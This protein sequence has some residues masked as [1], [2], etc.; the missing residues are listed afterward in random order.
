MKKCCFIIPY[1]GKL[2]V[3]FQL[4]LYSCGRNKDF[5]WLIF[6]DD[7]AQLDWPK[8]VDVV[9][10]SFE[11]T[12]ELVQSKFDFEIVLDRPYKLCDYKP[13][14][15]YIFEEYIQEY[16]FWGHC[17]C[18]MLFGCLNDFIP[19]DTMCKFDKLFV[20]GHCC[21]YKNT[22]ENNRVFMKNCKG[23]ERYK[24]VYTTDLS[25]T[26]DEEY[27]PNN[28]NTIFKEHKYQILEEDYSANISF[29]H[30]DFRLVRYD[31]TMNGYV[32]EEK[33]NSL[34]IYDNGK[35]KRYIKTDESIEKKEYMY[36]HFQ[37]REMKNFLSNTG[38]EYFKIVPNRFVSLEVE[39]VNMDN[40]DAIK[41]VYKNNHMQ[42]YIAG[43][44]RFWRKKILRKIL[45]K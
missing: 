11:K 3:N 45:G 25:C 4:F 21:I 9:H 43:E 34:F 44:I 33:G 8:N 18:D 15:G 10:T 32:N 37:K 22:K 19:Y 17:D 31:K 40:Y 23:I 16:E 28:V 29:R 26:F 30:T 36:I 24:E 39:S 12:K 6:T 2:P 1:F 13:A 5:N 41:K 35:I 20:L 27:L 38:S 42:K 14:Y 7:K